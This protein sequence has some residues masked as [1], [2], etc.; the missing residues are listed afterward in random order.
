MNRKILT[1]LMLSLVIAFCLP[2]ATQKKDFPQ[3][4]FFVRVGYGNLVKGTSA[5]TLSTHSY[6]RKLSQGVS[7]DAEYRFRPIRHLAVGLIYSAFSSK[8]SHDEGSDHFFTHYLAPQISI[9]ALATE[10]WQ[11]S[12]G[13][14]LGKLFYRNNSYV[15]GKPRQVKG[16]TWGPH[17]SL[18]A[19][20]KLNRHWGIGTG[21]QY[22]AGALNSVRSH[23]HGETI[24]VKFRNENQV[25]L[26][27]LN[28]AASLSYHF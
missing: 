8:G 10:K 4:E 17:V 28:I 2:L 9:Y 11:L 15:F 7:W 6:E 27:R 16:D 22:L 3:Q 26:T 18:Q 23:Y 25:D 14:G 24:T 1:T 5:L 13:V 20:Y 21:V 19:T 12:L